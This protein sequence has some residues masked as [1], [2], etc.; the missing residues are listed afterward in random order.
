MRQKP[1]IITLQTGGFISD[2]RP[3]EIVF[4]VGQRWWRGTISQ[5]ALFHAL[6]A[7]NLIHEDKE[8]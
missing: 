1:T 3:V 5:D 6:K 7:A 8:G 2:R 4:C